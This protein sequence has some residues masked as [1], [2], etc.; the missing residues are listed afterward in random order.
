[1]LLILK[2]FFIFYLHVWR[3][4]E[5]G[6]ARVKLCQ[7]S[8]RWR[9]DSVRP[10]DKLQCPGRQLIRRSEE[11]FQNYAVIWW[12]LSIFFSLKGVGGV[13]LLLSSSWDKWAEAS[14]YFLL[15]R[16][17]IRFSTTELKPMIHNQFRLRNVLLIDQMETNFSVGN[18]TPRK[19]ITRQAKP[20]SFGPSTAYC[21]LLRDD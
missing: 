20:I 7:C 14:L 5:T 4:K 12:S 21:M 18:W 11:H 16:S 15:Q 8:E 9:Q 10:A 13:S 3:Q 17:C 1:M 6:S 2:L 19:L